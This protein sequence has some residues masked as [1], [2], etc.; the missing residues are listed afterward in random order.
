MLRCT[1]AIAIL[2]V[3]T[4]SQIAAAPSGFDTL[5]EEYLQDYY[6]AHPVRATQLG[7]HDHDRLMPDLSR[8]AVKT[9]V[10]QLRAWLVRLEAPLELS[11]D[12]AVD[13]RLLL[14]AAQA[15][16]FE[17]EESRGWERDPMLY[18]R[19]MA[20]GAASLV[21]REFAP[22]DQRLERLL[23]RLNE[24]P[25][26]IATAKK[27]LRDVPAEWIPIALEIARGNL[28]FIETSVQTALQQQGLHELPPP[29]RARWALLRRSTAA[30][31]REFIG[32]IETD[33]A[34]AADGNFR[35]GRERF[36]RKLLYEEHLAIDVERLVALNEERIGFYTEWVER[37]AR[38]IDP[39]ADARAVMRAIAQD[40]PDADGL[41]EA[42]QREVERAQTFVTEREIL[43]LP[44]QTL[45]LVRATPDYARSGFA[46]MSIPGPFEEVA[47]ESYYNITNVDP[48]WSAEQQ[49]QHL[50]YFNHPGLLGV[51]IHEA[52]P[53]HFVQMHYKRR[54]PSN[55]RRVL[56]GATLVEGWAHYVEQMMIDEGLGS[57]RPEI[58]LGQ[59]RRA[60]QR[61]ARWY[62]C[63]ALHTTDASIDE[64]AARFAEIAYFAEFPARREVLRGTY[65]PL[66]LSY[67]LG[68]MQIFELRE[69][70]RDA[71][72]ADGSGFSL[73]EFHDRFLKL[74]LPAS[75]AREL[76]LG[77]TD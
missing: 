18:N 17:L 47:T 24:Y 42:A 27:N 55:V 38:R 41:I 71:R 7:I 54:L 77:T 25:R 20:E 26:L 22:L 13:R 19:L 36:E 70:Y 21:E 6:R 45:P 44:T 3:P 4:G 8:A 57:G 12:Q 63:L 72:T 2:L 11:P 48:E 33:L 23:D 73:R 40:H 64:V 9:R 35:L 76:M 37:E 59:L 30:A 52:M 50:T 69:S 14:D 32:W 43:T 46:S 62:A 34:R 31:I 61:H 15:E 5:A 68:R 49:A 56:G 16:L 65:D 39:Q 53:G 75:L 66:Y 58:R 29:P 67:A 10:K 51:S 74:G 28:T 60:L 1:L